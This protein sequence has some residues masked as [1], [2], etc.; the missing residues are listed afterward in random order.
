MVNSSQQPR[1]RRRQAG[2][3]WPGRRSQPCGFG[4]LPSGPRPCRAC[5][6]CRPP[7]APEERL[8]PGW[9]GPCESAGAARPPARCLGWGLGPGF[10]P[11]LPG[12]GGAGAV[13]L[14]A[15]RGPARLARSEFMGPGRLAP[16]AR[17]IGEAG[18]RSKALRGHFRARTGPGA[19]PKPLP[20]SL[21]RFHS[22]DRGPTPPGGPGLLATP[23]GP[24]WP[25]CWSRRAGHSVCPSGSHVSSSFETR[26]ASW[27]G[28]LWALNGDENCPL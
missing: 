20:Q 19:F 14:A 1:G 7:S 15:L 10:S 2:K 8:L 9:Q 27:C 6:W 22:A 23:T 17:K 13:T 4:L 12:E 11:R 18:R 24:W 16:E 25:H 5:A 28:L 26:G 3:L 21:L